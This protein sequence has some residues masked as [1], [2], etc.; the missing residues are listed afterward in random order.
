MKAWLVAILEVLAAAV[1]WGLDRFGKRVERD[2]A[3]A[4]EAGLLPPA[5][6]PTGKRRIRVRRSGEEFEL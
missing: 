4:E 3:R 5:P 6:R 1:L 2:R